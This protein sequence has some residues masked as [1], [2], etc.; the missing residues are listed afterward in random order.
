MPEPEEERGEDKGPHAFW[1]GTLSFGLVAIPVQLLAG[2]RGRSTSLRAVSG[3]GE[4]LRRE[5]Y[6][7][8]DGQTLGPEDLVRGWEPPEGDPVLVSDEEL[9][10]LEPE[11][12]RDIDLRR[13]VPVAELDPAAFDRAW[14]LAPDGGSTK[15]YRLLARVLEQQQRAGIATFVLRG[16]EHLIALLSAG[17]VLRAQSLRFA[18]ELR[19][20]QEAGLPV[21]GRADA[22]LARRLRSALHKLHREDLPEEALVDEAAQALRARAEQKR[23]RGEGLI[24][25][26]GSAD[27]REERGRDGDDVVEALRRSLKATRGGGRSRTRSRREPEDL[28][29]GLSKEELYERARAESIPGR[30]R[31][32]KAELVR[33]LRQA[34]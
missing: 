26:A 18:D 25:L 4:P 23:A 30:S 21:E 1:S 14:W 24:E 16:R 8:E 32:S 11:R 34:G 7:P 33:A 13:F 10:G 15:A 27:A 29:A 20:P 19:P 22:A 6:C 28:L 3:Q 9:E 31:M 12:S 2:Q 5:Y 17:G